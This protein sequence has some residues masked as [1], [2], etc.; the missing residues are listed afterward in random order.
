MNYLLKMGLFGF[1]TNSPF[2]MPKH[3][4]T[5]AKQSQINVLKYNTLQDAVKYIQ[6]QVICY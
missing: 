1:D 3:Q 6:R 2:F 4:Q 5:K